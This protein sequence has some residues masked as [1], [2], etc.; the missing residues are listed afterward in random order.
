[1]QDTA[2]KVDVIGKCNEEEESFL[3][4]NTFLLNR[5]IE[6]VSSSVMKL[7]NIIGTLSN[8]RNT[9][10]ST[11]GVVDDILLIA[12]ELLV[13]HNVST[14]LPTSCKEIKQEQPI[15]PSGLYLLANPNDTSLYY[16]YCDMGTLCGS[17]GGW[18]RLA[19][20]DMSDSTMNR[21]SG[22]RLYQSGGVRACGRATSSGGSCVSVQFPS[23]SISYSQ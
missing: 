19:Y 8:I 21:P 10:T 7:N 13:L 22:F 2:N 16:T 9:S 3:E 4:N 20:L 17:G 6:T 12:Q 18:T 14:A 11:A 15:S 1:M 5:V 23:N